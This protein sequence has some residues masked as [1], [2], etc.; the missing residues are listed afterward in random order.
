M[1]LA[2]AYNRGWPWAWLQHAREAIGSAAV[3]DIGHRL[4]AMGLVAVYAIGHRPDG[5]VCD[6]P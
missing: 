5:S 3:Y 4:E 1:G 6:R 2:A